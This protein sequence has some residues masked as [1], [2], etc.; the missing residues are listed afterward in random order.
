MPLAT[1][2]DGVSDLDIGHQARE[3]VD[4]EKLPAGSGENAVPAA[5]RRMVND[6]LLKPPDQPWEGKPK[7]RTCNAHD[8][9]PSRPVEHHADDEGGNDAD[10][11]CAWTRA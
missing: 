8:N 7:H 3:E 1:R 2:G 6:E 9:G 5:K 4:L 10:S 11:P